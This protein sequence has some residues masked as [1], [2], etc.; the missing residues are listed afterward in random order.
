MY[1]HAA[2]NSPLARLSDEMR[3]QGFSLFR[4][5][6]SYPLSQAQRNLAGRTFFMSP[7]TMKF[8]KAKVHRCSILESGLVLAMVDST[9]QDGA[10]REYRPAFFDIFGTCIERA[11]GAGSFKTLAAAEKAYYRRCDEI[12]F[13]A[14]YREALARQ[15]EKAMRLIG[16]CD[17]ALEVVA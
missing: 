3:K 7:D 16:Q 1:H 9:A 8:F 2:D 6:S 15:K 13:L 10:A 17:A 12:D 5:E 14:H 4:E 11:V